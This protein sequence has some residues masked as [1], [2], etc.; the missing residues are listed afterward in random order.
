MKKSIIA[1]IAFCS[2]A[3]VS[4]ASAQETGNGCEIDPDWKQSKIN[5]TLSACKDRAQ[6]M[7]PEAV[8]ENVSAYAEVAK[9][10]A[11]AI[12]IAAREVGIAVDEFVKTDTGKLTVALIVWHVAGDDI[13]S[14]VIGIPCIIFAVFLWFAITNRTKRTGEFEIIKNRWGKEQSI[15]KMKPVS[16]LDGPD[17]FSYLVASLF[18]GAIVIVCLANIF[19]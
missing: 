19:T 9:G 16:D 6:S 17:G 11:E 7:D 1:A 10:V 18:C 15:H 5:E 4:V 3:F 14:I 8:A 2:M 13:I 12:G